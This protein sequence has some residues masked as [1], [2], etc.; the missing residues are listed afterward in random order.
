MRVDTVPA[1]TLINAARAVTLDEAPFVRSDMLLRAVKVTNPHPN[2][3]RI[4]AVR[5][6]AMAGREA[7]RTVQYTPERI[8]QRALDLVP[9]LGPFEKAPDNERSYFGTTG[10]WHSEPFVSCPELAG[11]QMTGF[12]LEQVVV[13]AQDP[14]DAL[15]VAVDYEGG[16]GQG[17]ANLTL[18][19]RE[20]VPRNTYTFPLRGSW[21]VVNNWDDLHGH[22]DGISQEFAIDLVQP[23]G[24]GLF[25]LDQP[26]EAYRFYGADVL[27]AADGEVVVVKDFCPENPR[28]GLRA[29]IDVRKIYREH[30]MKA[31]TAGNH[32]IIRHPHGEC[33]FYA[34]LIRGSIRVR[35][36][37]RVRQGQV[38]GSLGNCGSSD[39]PH[40]H[41]H[42][43][44][45]AELGA[46]GL[47]CHFA[48]I[49]DTFDQPCAFITQNFSTVR[50][51]D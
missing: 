34:H 4:R 37:D 48:N 46:R 9:L 24:E 17:S 1:T 44:D 27:A 23:N 14:I 26:N 18:P 20:Y 39:A 51:I 36:G 25:P 16:D 5:L 15:I 31:I 12:M 30:G 40:L 49:V 45:A 42:L 22:R 41:F 19:V 35:E 29:E 47:P 10:F 8:A 7:L 32:V 21:L 33:S 38:L 50:T 3:A 11:G 28:A 2:P 13:L 6:T 43:M